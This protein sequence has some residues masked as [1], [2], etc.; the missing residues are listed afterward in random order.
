[1]S[2]Q[3]KIINPKLNWIILHDLNTRDMHREPH[4]VFSPFLYIYF[5]IYVHMFIWV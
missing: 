5:L 1:M 2:K 4:F 3:Y